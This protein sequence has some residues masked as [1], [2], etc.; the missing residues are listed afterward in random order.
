MINCN[1]KT[2]IKLRGRFKLQVVN[3]Q[4]EVVKE[5]SW[6]DNLITNQGLDQIG[7]YQLAYNAGGPYLNITCAVGTSN[8]TPSI[9]DTQ[10]GAFLAASPG[11]GS[12]I[13][14]TTRTYVAGPPSYWSCIWVYTFVAGSATGTISEIGVGN[15]I[16]NTD[17][18]PW[19]FSHALITSGGIPTTITVLSNE[20]LIVTYELDYYI[21]T[22]TNSYS[23]SMSTVTYS[24]SYLRSRVSTTPTLNIACIF[25]AFGNNIPYLYVYNG[26]IGTITGFPSGSQSGGPNSCTSAYAASYSNGNYY[27]S[28][29]TSFTISQG[30]VSG[31]ITSFEVLTASMG[32]WQFSVTPNIPK[33]SSYQM[34]ITYAVSWARY[35]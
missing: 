2:D 6:F 27:N 26:S 14:S 31:G 17:T 33:T 12:A 22:T 29:I 24:G 1:I 5:L 15:W 3:E 21:N 25:G 16:S 34:S 13:T 4:Q 28:F 11:R 10:M 8:A 9:T 7:G 23:F 35:P 18:Q 32:S 19:L 20:S 30:N